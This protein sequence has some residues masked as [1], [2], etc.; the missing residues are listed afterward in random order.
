MDAPQLRR[1]ISDDGHFGQISNT[2]QQIASKWGAG[3]AFDDKDR[4]ADIETFLGEMRRR[5]LRLPVVHAREPGAPEAE[6]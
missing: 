1:F 6:S 5:M 3:I 4:P 2:E